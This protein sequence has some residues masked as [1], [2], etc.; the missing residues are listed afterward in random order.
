LSAG[1]AFHAVETMIGL[2]FG[3]ASLLYLARVPVPRWAVAGA[4]GALAAVVGV[5]S[6]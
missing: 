2:A 1:I 3:S 4:S 5:T 6:F